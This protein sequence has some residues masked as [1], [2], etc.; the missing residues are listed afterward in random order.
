ME[1]LN[2][3]LA[4]NKNTTGKSPNPEI[5]EASGYSPFQLQL[6]IGFLL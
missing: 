6:D 2:Y 3:S 4:G 5:K 1:Y